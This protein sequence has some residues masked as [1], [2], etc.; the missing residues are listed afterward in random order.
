MNLNLPH[1]LWPVI[2][3][4]VH[5][6]MCCTK[7]QLSY[8]SKLI[9]NEFLCYEAQSIKEANMLIIWGSFTKKL[10]DIL[11]EHID[12]MI[13]RH[14]ILHIVGCENRIENAHSSSALI[15]TLP[16]NKIVYE[17][18]F[19]KNSIQLLMNEVR[20]CLRA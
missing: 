2:F 8:E 14:C 10:C 13:N 19:K 6:T 9:S 17:C 3:F 7:M 12:D 4:Q 16:I 5:G 20:K 18:D 11:H 1:S 15:N